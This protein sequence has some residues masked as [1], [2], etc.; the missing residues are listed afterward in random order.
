MS[1]C[2][3]ISARDTVI[4][5]EPS[6]FVAGTKVRVDATEWRAR[7]FGFGV[8]P[9]HRYDGPL[10]FPSLVIKGILQSQFTQR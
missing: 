10:L 3:P 6:D 1:S 5:T 8:R 7:R 4:R 2:K 9:Y